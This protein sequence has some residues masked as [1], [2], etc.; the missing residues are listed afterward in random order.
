MSSPLQSTLLGLCL[1]LAVFS[2]AAAEDFGVYKPYSLKL[3]VSPMG[4]YNSN[5]IALGDGLP[6]PEGVSRQDAGFFE[7]DTAAT[8]DWKATAVGDFVPDQ[9]TASYEYTQD[10]YEGI[11]GY[12]LGKHSWSAKYT[13]RFNKQ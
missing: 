13:H 4:G 1:V 12:D 3:S 6:L 7:I 8:F 9:F 2:F 11:S 10:F 5:V